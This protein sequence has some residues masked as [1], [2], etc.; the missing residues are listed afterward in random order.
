MHEHEE[1]LKRLSVEKCRFREAFCCRQRM[2][3]LFSNTLQR[4]QNHN[5]NH[6]FHTKSNHFAL[7][8][9]ILPVKGVGELL[10]HTF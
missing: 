4:H 1:N 7:K 2:A 9:N 6:F 5:T 10:F 8:E 3:P